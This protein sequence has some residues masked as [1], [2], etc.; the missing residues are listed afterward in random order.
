MP[1][2]EIYIPPADRA[3]RA[4]SD[5]IAVQVRNVMLTQRGLPQPTPPAGVIGDD[6]EV[7]QKHVATCT[8]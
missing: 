4:D 5:R 3:R 1:D 7:W 6:A 2:Q 8:L